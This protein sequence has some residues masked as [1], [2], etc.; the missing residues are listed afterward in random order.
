MFEFFWSPFGSFAGQG[1]WGAMGHFVSTS[2]AFGC[3]HFGLFFS[4]VFVLSFPHLSYP[5]LFSAM[6]TFF[7]VMD[8]IIF[9][10]PASIW[11][12][13]LFF[14]FLFFFRL[15]CP[16]ACFP[17]PSSRLCHPHV[18]LPREV[19]V[20]PGILACWLFLDVDFRMG[21][22]SPRCLEHPSSYRT[23]VARY[24][25]FIAFGNTSVDRK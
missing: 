11:P 21:K 4:Y 6:W 2:P 13:F 12:G 5:C 23:P 22:L 18:P 14:A 10:S 9:W 20:M 25:A 3:L 7:P 17:M 24:M 16:L 8:S 1:G 15:W 19:S